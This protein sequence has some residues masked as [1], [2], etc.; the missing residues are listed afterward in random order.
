MLT[1]A[2]GPAV[3]PAGDDAVVCPSGLPDDS[4]CPLSA[5]SYKDEIQPIV[6]AY[7]GGCHYAGNRNSSQV[8]E[9]YDELHQSLSLVEKQ[10]YHCEMPPSG[11]TPLPAPDR[12]KLLQWLVCGAPNN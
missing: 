12:T 8:L 9:T 5:A 10:V 6:D 11:E 7:C 3:K 2:C 1:T 4:G